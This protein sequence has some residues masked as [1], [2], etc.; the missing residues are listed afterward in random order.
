MTYN[1]KEGYR[2]VSFGNS[3]DVIVDFQTERVMKEGWKVIYKYY[4]RNPKKAMSITMFKTLY[5][6]R[7]GKKVSKESINKRT[8]S[9]LW[10]LATF[11]PKG[12][13]IPVIRIESMP[14]RFQKSKVLQ[15]IHINNPEK[16][17][18]KKK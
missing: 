16:V 8:C 1:S 4:R 6:R 12:R 18:K 15:L 5:F 17:F 11:I 10:K 2:T 14:T 3:K 13:R 9:F 7:N